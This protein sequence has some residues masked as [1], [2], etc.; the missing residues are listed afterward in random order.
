MAAALL[1]SPVYAQGGFLREADDIPLAPALEEAADGAAFTGAA[2]RL[3][4]LTASGAAT[5]ADV[6][7][8]YEAAMAP[9]GWS[10]PPGSD[11][12][13]VFQRG[14]ERLTITIV[15]NG[16]VVQ[17]RYRLVTRGASMALD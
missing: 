9:L 17:V 5:G 12:P 3:L 14:R 10:Q 11:G 6:R 1:A 2:G 15:A 7:A 4:A 13:L 8:F 16:A